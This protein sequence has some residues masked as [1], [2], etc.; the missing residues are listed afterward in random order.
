MGRRMSGVEGICDS[1]LPFLVNSRGVRS[2]YLWNGID[3]EG[4]SRWAGG[5]ALY[6]WSTSVGV[7][8]LKYLINSLV[9]TLLLASPCD[10][11][12]LKDSR[13]PEV[14]L[15]LDARSI[16]GRRDTMLRTPVR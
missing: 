10:V 13:A 12:K 6:T 16:A 8:K 9:L 7:G 14:W 15:W 5:C 4:P 2:R 11:V 3:Q 1:G